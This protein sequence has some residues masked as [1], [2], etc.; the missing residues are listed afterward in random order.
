MF[1]S[2]HY[3]TIKCRRI[4]FTGTVFDNYR[5][6]SEESDGVFSEC[7]NTYQ[8]HIRFSKAV[9][10]RYNESGLLKR[11]GYHTRC[12]TLRPD[13][14]VPQLWGFSLRISYTLSSITYLWN[15]R[16]RGHSVKVIHKVCLKFSKDHSNSGNVCRHW[17]SDCM[18]NHREEG[19]NKMKGFGNGLKDSS[20]GYIWWPW[21]VVSHKKFLSMW[22]YR[23]RYTRRMLHCNH[24]KVSL[25]P[26][27]KKGKVRRNRTLTPP[28]LYAITIS[29]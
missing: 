9:V 26:T 6:D 28:S 25:H 1:Y 16:I 13:F 11:P 5:V 15:G 29:I 23:V 17:T 18:E 22:L 27:N 20:R 12:E 7:R 14:L 4:L 19:R 8:R 3:S 21:E 2:R 24:E 10:R